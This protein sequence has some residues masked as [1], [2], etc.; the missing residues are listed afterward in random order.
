M[1]RGVRVMIIFCL[2]NPIR[3]PFPI[4][5]STTRRSLARKIRGHVTAEPVKRPPNLITKRSPPAR[6]AVANGQRADLNVTY[7][8]FFTLIAIF[9]DDRGIRAG[10][11]PQLA[12]SAAIFHAPVL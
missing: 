11:T 1:R 3:V 6:A 2:S 4:P 10:L 5:I 9:V 12:Q 7:G 8:G